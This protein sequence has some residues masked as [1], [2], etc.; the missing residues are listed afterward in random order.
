MTGRINDVLMAEDTHAN[1][2][3]ATAVANGTL[4][5]CSTH[6]LIYRSDGSSWSTWATLGSSGAVLLSTVTAAGDLIVGSGSG[7]VTNLA[8]GSALQVLR[9]NAGGTALE[10]ATPAGGSSNPPVMVELA[11]DLTNITTTTFTTR[12]SASFT[13]TGTAMRV[14]V[15]GNFVCTG[16]GEAIFQAV[17]DNGAG[18]AGASLPL[19]TAGTNSQEAA[20]SGARKFTGLTAGLTYAVTLQHKQDGGSGGFYCRPVGSPFVEQLS[21]L[22]QDVA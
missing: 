2:P 16:I 17:R 11:T 18:G 6:N 15:A 13:P 3:V 1:R 20:F 8:K 9:V 12:L 4:Y 21:M 10:Y 22:L 7:A 5:K 19:G 14:S